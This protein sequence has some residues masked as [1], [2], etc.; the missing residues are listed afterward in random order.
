MWEIGQASPQPRACRAE[1]RDD[2]QR[3]NLTQDHALFENAPEIRASLPPPL[4][5]MYPS[6]HQST[7]CFS[8]GPSA[9]ISGSLTCGLLGYFPSSLHDVTCST[10]VSSRLHVMCS[11]VCI[12]YQSTMPLPFFFS[13]PIPLLLTTH[14]Y[15]SATLYQ[16]TTPTQHHNI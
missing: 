4:A 7:P 5:I 9:D 14:N 15:Q 2:V 13:F 11:P 3:L 1:M 12:L 6:I 16:K 8:V 10:T